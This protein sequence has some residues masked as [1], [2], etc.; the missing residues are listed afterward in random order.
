MKEIIANVPVNNIATILTKDP[1]P[2]EIDF[3]N[4]VKTNAIKI[5]NVNITAI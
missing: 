4:L 1:P 5:N 2:S 3:S